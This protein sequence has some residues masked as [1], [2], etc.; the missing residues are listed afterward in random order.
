M[1]F[2]KKQIYLTLFIVLYGSIGVSQDIHFSQFQFT[3]TLINPATAGT[4]LGDFRGMLNFKEQYSS[5]NKAFKTYHASFDMP[6][7][8]D[9]KFKKTGAGLDFFQ[10]VAGDSKTKITSVTLNLSQTIQFSR[11]SD[12]SLGI[13]MGYSQ[14]SANY[15]SLAW[16]TQF[17]GLDYDSELPSQETFFG[18][19]QGYFDFSTG[20]FYRQFDVNGFPYELGV[21]VSHLTTPSISLS[22]D[23]DELPT[24]ITIHGKKEFQLRQDRW[25][26]I[27]LFFLAKQRQAYEVNGG[28]LLRYDLGMHSKYTGYY[29]SSNM[30]LGATFRLGDAI[31]P[32]I[33]L[34]LKERYTMAISYDINISN[35]ARASKFRGGLEVSLVMSG[36]VKHKYQVTSPVTF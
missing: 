29:R 21:S 1:E 33:G 12:L 36:F 5:F 2:I 10:D 8:S 25:G 30:Y 24:K 4:F 32:Q 3:P 27:P 7:L 13:S 23:L 22:G 35:L 26:I 28:A 16:G 19:S 11:Y 20:L 17:N 14:H 9:L 31:I 15:V 6:V 34:N 18:R